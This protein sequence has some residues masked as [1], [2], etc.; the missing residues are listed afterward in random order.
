MGKKKKKNS[1]D[2][3]EFYNSRRQNDS[4]KKD[5]DKKDKKRDKDVQ[6]A[7]IRLKSVHMSLDKDDIKDAAKVIRTP[8]EVPKKFTNVREKCNHAGDTIT[9]AEY[10]AMTPSYAVYTPM[11]DPLCNWFGEDAVA[12]CEGCYD[13]LVDFTKVKASDV[14][15][16]ICILYAAANKAISMKRM[17]KDA[18]KAS[19]KMKEGLLDWEEIVHIVSKIDEAVGE[20]AAASRAAKGP[21]LNDVGNS[22]IVM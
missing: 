16:A 7:N 2:P 5:K 11:L 14:E 12:V 6:L 20:S 21:N 22:P 10:R 15:G 3:F 18:L 1:K 9:P 4:R 17:K 19:I 8:V 13:V